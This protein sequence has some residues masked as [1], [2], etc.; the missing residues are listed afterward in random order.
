[1]GTWFYKGFPKYELTGGK[2]LRKGFIPEGVH[3]FLFDVQGKHRFINKA[4]RVYHR[5]LEDEHSLANN[6]YDVKNAFGLSQSYLTF[7]NVYADKIYSYP[8]T[9]LRN[10]IGYQY[11][12]F[13]NNI[14]FPKIISNPQN[15]VIKLLGLLTLPLSF[16]YHKLK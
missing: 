8:K 2:I 16:I 11:Y 4:V 5:D 3:Q 1:M 9:L 14:S 10:L 15:I 7:I 6:F 12:S 13:K